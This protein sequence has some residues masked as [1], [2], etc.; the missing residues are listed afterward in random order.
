[1]RRILFFWLLIVLL[2]SCNLRENLLLPPDISAADYQT[3]NAIRIFSDY[4]IKSE[5]DDSY[6]LLHKESIA[7]E[8]IHLGDEI[9]FRKVKTFAL[10]DSLG[11]QNNAAE[12]S[13]T[14][15]FSV[16]RSGNIINLIASI[17]MAEIYTEVKPSSDPFYLVYLNYY[18][19]A[20]SIQPIFYRKDR[21]HFPVSTTGE[22][23]LFSIPTEAN[24]A[25]QHHSGD[26]FYAL[27]LNSA[28]VQV[29][30]NFP[31]SFTSSAGEITIRIKNQL[32]SNEQSQLAS[33][34]PDAAISYP[35]ID[36]QT[37]RSPG[38]ELAYIRILNSG[39][40]FWGRQWIYLSENSVY[41][42][43]ENDPPSGN[44]NWWIDSNGLYSFLKGSGKYF[45]LTPLENQQDVTIPLDGSVNYV[46][47]QQVWFDLR[48]LSLPSTT[49]KVNINPDLSYLLADY[50]NNNPYSFNSSLQ[51]FTMEF[52][53]ASEL[54]STLPDSKWIEFGF[55]THLPSDVHNRLFC[56]ERNNLQ[57]IIT[58]KKPADS[59][60]AN[61]FVQIGSYLYSSIAA[62][63]TYLFGCL[64]LPT[65]QLTVNYCKNRQYLQ[66][67]NAIISWWNTT[68]NDYDNLNL[69]LKP[70]IPNHPWL[71][72]EPFNLSSSVSLAEFYFYKNTEVQTTLPTGFYLSLPVATPQEN[73]LLFSTLPFPRLKHYLLG[74]VNF[75]VQNGW[76]NIYPDFPGRIINS[77]INYSHPFNLRTYSTMT[78]SFADLI[79]YTYGN[80]PQDA[81]VNFSFNLTNS[82]ADPYQI[83]ANQYNL[84]SHS[85]TYAISSDSE[86]NFALFQPVL[87]FRRTAKGQNLLFYEKTEPYYRLYAYTESA[88]FDPWHFYL[89]NGFNGIALT[90]SGSYASFVDNN[91]HAN[92]TFSLDNSNRDAII[93]LYQAQLVLPAFFIDNGV[94]LGSNLFL[95]KLDSVLGVANLISAYQFNITNSTGTAL[96]PDF[97]N[98]IGATQE[99][100]IYIP[101]PDVTILDTAH[102]F[103]RD[104]DGNET[105]LNQVNAFSSNYANE[106]IV[107]GNCLICTVPNPGIF[108]ISGI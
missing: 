31:S 85:A 17:N 36:L 92:V 95:T 67:E 96:N 74:S 52:Y 34:F 21:A 89:D 24:P 23:A 3:G 69:N 29:A 64:T 86:D 2:S 26:N 104:Q 30:V 39:K 49:L 20:D 101:V 60:D 84:S 103:Y 73:F 40:G 82:L 76:L 62:S 94:P 80:A 68:K 70:A 32:N 8:L 78:F 105:E 93:S 43:S 71:Q 42:W 65:S 28:G 15:Q 83:L 10:R 13:N 48:S 59:Y 79:L 91:P 11:F 106:Y 51:A 38:N 55:F 6:L 37:E 46:F 77:K 90:N 5:N 12:Q 41:G 88:T 35:I 27:L 14:Y 22:Y 66:T 45:L 25:L 54:L 18:L 47:L 1:M 98:I 56:I 4:L 87:F 53:Y 97:Y 100:Y 16:L 33:Y 58:F 102:L 9:V 81:N 50:F 99:P 57:D 7:E 44:S 72:G 19:Q 108:Y 107:V 61:H 75:T 63:A